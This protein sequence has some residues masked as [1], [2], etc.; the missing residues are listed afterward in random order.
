MY[1]FFFLIF[2]RNRDFVDDFIVR[3][4]K[5]T[6]GFLILKKK[7]QY[8]GVCLSRAVEGRVACSRLRDSWAC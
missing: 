3:R 2:N 8:S 1:N 7:K 5:K 4:V 6:V